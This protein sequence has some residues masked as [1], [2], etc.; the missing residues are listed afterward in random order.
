VTNEFQGDAPASARRR[1]I[2][3]AFAAPAALTLVSGSVYAAASNQRCLQNAQNPPAIAPTP[4]PDTWLRVQLWTLVNGNGNGPI[5]SW[6]RG[7]DLAA[8]RV[9]GTN[10]PYLPDGS[11]QPVTAETGSGFTAGVSQASTPTT[12]NGNTPQ[13]SGQYVAV[14]V[15]SVGN[16]VGVQGVGTGGGAAVSLVCWASF[17]GRA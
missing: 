8:L 17:A 12:S 6:V 13:A 9:P 7:V 1:L 11:W 16:I 3:G 10:A 5:S 4:A 15:D 2:R 14:R